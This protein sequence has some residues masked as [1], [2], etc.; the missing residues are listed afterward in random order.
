MGLALVGVAG[1]AT[2]TSEEK[3]G[4]II[5]TTEFVISLGEKKPSFEVRVEYLLLLRSHNLMPSVTAEVVNRS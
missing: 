1:I 2:H 5:V 3:E 4:G